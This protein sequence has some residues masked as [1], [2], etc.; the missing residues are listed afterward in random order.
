MVTWI[1][2]L[3]APLHA[4]RSLVPLNR[5]VPT[6]VLPDGG[7]PIDQVAFALAVARCN[8]WSRCASLAP[9]V[10]SQCIQALSQNASWHFTT[11]SDRSAGNWQDRQCAT[12]TV[13]FLFPN[14]AI[15]QAVRDGIVRYDPE[16]EG[17]CLQ[18]LQSQSCHGSDLWQAISACTHTFTCTPD[19]EVGDAGSGGG[20]ASDGGT[21]CSALLNPWVVPKETLLPCS[22]ASDCTNVT[23]PGGPYCVDG[24]CAPGSHGDKDYC[25]LADG[26]ACEFVDSGQPC[27]SN[28]PVL[29]QMWATPWGAWPTKVCS[30]GLTCAGL[31]SSGSLG[32]CSAA[33]DI[34]EP[35]R[36][37]AAIAG[38]RIGL[39]CQCGTCQIPPSRGPC[40]SGSCQIGIAYCDLKSNTCMP[41]KQMGGDCTAGPQAC[42]PNLE[43]DS[44]NTCQPYSPQ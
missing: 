25:Q 15:F 39:S 27:D 16:Q 33:Q 10:V 4:S 30:P 1:A 6:F 12:A 35:C 41:V 18:Q 19:A 13:E 21:V 7:V 14:A 2:V 37:G 17:A 22:T 43:C 28:P 34:G 8:Y 38:C 44:E 36:Q 5:R 9:Y 20:V 24:Y 23:S 11:C 26:G 29:G 3:R 31:T 32:V 42:P 40:D